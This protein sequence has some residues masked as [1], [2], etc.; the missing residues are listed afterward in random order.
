MDDRERH[1]IINE[2]YADFVVEYNN[3]LNFFERYPN[4][5][6]NLINEK[7]AVLHVPVQYFGDNA[8]QEFGYFILPKCFGLTAFVTNDMEGIKARSVHAGENTGMGILI[9][10]IDSGI[11][12]RST[13]FIKEDNTTKIELLWDQSIDSNK[14]PDGFY[15]GTEYTASDINRALSTDNPM[16]VVPSMDII[17]EGT[18]MAGVA[19][20][21]SS[22]TLEEIG[23]VPGASLAVVKLKTAKKYL[24]EFYGIPETAVCYQQNDIMMGIEY[25]M[26]SAKRLGKP[27]AICLGLSS[28]QGSH[29]GEDI[30]SNYLNENANQP[31][32]CMV[33]GSGNEGDQNHHYYNKLTP[34]NT[35]DTV[36]LNVGKTDKNFTAEVWGSLPSLLEV[37]I[38]SPDGEKVYRVQ[39]DFSSQRN[40]H[41]SYQET[42]I[43]I[44]S[45]NSEAYSEQQLIMF[46]FRN[47]T[48]GIW[49][50]VVS[51][52]ESLESEFHIWLPIRNFISE[53]TYLFN[54]TPFTTISSPGNA[55][56]V[57][58]INTYE[59]VSIT[60][61]PFT[62]RGFT[63]V[64]FPKPT[65]TAPGVNLIAP[66]LF[67]A[68][69]P[70]S[71]SSLSTAYA[72]GI[73]AG[74][75]SDS[76]QKEEK[77]NLN[78]A[79]VKNMLMLK[80]VRRKNAIYPNPD[81]GYGYIQ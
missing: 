32:I 56:F 17:G 61:A 79:F 41:V 26:R 59:P 7:Y 36:F 47:M 71:G 72:A 53:D 49:R 75:L 46:R 63:S 52:T 8:I 77:N 67:G 13:Y 74:F 81:W 22:D 21:M 27:I 69:I 70:I 64:N 29:K 78:T 18:A 10:I 14:Y 20:G 44:D 33:I 51:G 45:Y 58:T 25:L 34:P 31:G 19:V 30:M 6:Y 73:C 16:E 66:T 15:Y 43:F 60:L 55:D 2:E 48:E 39:A 42:V 65:V 37:L 62:G 54:A 9:G 40:V 57:I 1:T 5:T 35:T 68:L 38:I 50:L 3:N 80:A 23:L 76:I 12:Y 11:D 24:M 4:S 28:S